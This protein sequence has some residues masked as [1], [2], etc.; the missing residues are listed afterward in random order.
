MHRLILAGE[1]QLTAPF[2]LLTLAAIIDAL[3]IVASDATLISEIL[4]VIRL[5][6][7]IVLFL[8]IILLLIR[9]ILIVLVDSDIVNE[10]C[11][12]PLFLS[13]LLLSVSLLIAVL[14]L[15]LR[16]GV[17]ALARRLNNTH[18]T[19]A[20]NQ[21][22]SDTN[23]HTPKDKTGHT[24]ALMRMCV[25]ADGWFLFFF[26]IAACLIDLRF[27]IRGGTRITHI[28]VRLKGGDKRGGKRMC[29]NHCVCVLLFLGPLTVSSSPCIVCCLVP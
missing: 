11:S 21:T 9:L 26:L 3:I 8:L 7:A 28:N 12:R 27:Q 1:V 2:R 23:E 17:G 10:L 22:I 18:T 16:G 14:I 24:S 4:T 6:V 13:V 20:H 5:T 19:Q 29:Q 25:F 15:I